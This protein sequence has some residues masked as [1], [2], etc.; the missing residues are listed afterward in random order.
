[1]AQVVVPY[2]A[3]R[4]SAEVAKDEARR[5]KNDG[6]EFSA[7]AAREASDTVLSMDEPEN[8]G[9]FVSVDS[10]TAATLAAD[11]TNMEYPESIRNMLEF[12]NIW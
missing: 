4:K 5:L 1:M 3:L 9:H 2:A 8:P 12:Y 11:G 10:S 6:L 7:K